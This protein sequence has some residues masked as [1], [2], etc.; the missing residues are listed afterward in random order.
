MKIKT[1]KC[2]YCEKKY[3]DEKI[4][5]KHK[6]R[7]KERYENKTKKINQLGFLLF[8]QHHTLLQ[9]A[10][11]KKTYGDF[12]KS[13]LYKLFINLA[14]Y[15]LET[16][17][18]YPEKYLNFLICNKIRTQLWNKD[19]SY[20]KYILDLLEKESMFD[21]VSRTL[22]LMQSWAIKNN[23][24]YNNFFKKAPKPLIYYYITQGEISP[25]VLYCSKSG[26]NF[27][28]SLLD[29]E[30]EKLKPFINPFSWRRK[31][32]INKKEVEFL[33]DLFTRENI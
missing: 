26:L 17:V 5:L 25:W 33:T 1:Y 11:I 14:T 10:K 24:T 4:F 21:G 27:L 6:C 12:V 30:I 20:E 15:V 18:L 7:F 29:E 13:S 9:G 8:E 19:V 2:E 31:L 23:D 16:K 28:K 22:K 32:I 3:K